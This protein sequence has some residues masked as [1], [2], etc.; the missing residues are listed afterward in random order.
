[1][2]IKNMEFA[3]LILTLL[4]VTV[5]SRYEWNA[6]GVR[7]C[8]TEYSTADD[9]IT[10][11]LSDG[12]A[13]YECT[14]TFS[15]AGSWYHCNKDEGVQGSDVLLSGVS[16]DRI[17][18]TRDEDTGN[19]AI[20]LN[21]FV[22]YTDDGMI[23]FWAP[24]NRGWSTWSKGQWI[25]EGGSFYF[26]LKERF[27]GQTAPAFTPDDVTAS[28]PT[29]SPTAPT[30]SPSAA[31]PSPTDAVEGMDAHDVDGMDQ[32]ENVEEESFSDVGHSWTDGDYLDN[33]GI[34]I[35]ANPIYIDRELP[36]LNGPSFYFEMPSTQFH[37]AVFIILMLVMMN[38]FC[39]AMT[40]IEACQKLKRKHLKMVGVSG[41][42]SA[43][44]S[45]NADDKEKV[46]LLV[47]QFHIT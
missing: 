42:D 40:R 16:F 46:N 22:L 29:P 32:E 18:I 11:S 45:Q 44:E 25:D 21:E 34:N 28:A 1:M 4:S 2:K 33:D 13:I 24:I 19:D 26:D 7:T 31:T 9:S 6:F 36:A 41:L 47:E 37:V 14:L 3:G 35:E 30:P 15:T 12:A 8:N 27:A 38:L 5:W 39:L 23:K 10:I 17:K 20:C 43:D